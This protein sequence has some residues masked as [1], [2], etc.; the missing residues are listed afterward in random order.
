MLLVAATL[1]DAIIPRPTLS[2]IAAAKTRLTRNLAEPPRRR[3]YLMQR[4]VS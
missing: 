1:L 3:R 4:L 2:D